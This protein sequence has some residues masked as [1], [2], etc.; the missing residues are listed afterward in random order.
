MTPNIG[1]DSRNEKV[2]TSQCASAYVE[3]T[4]KL[5]NPNSDKC[6]GSNFETNPFHV[7]GT[8]FNFTSLKGLK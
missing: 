6:V 2:K 5:A 4:L 1:Y 8:Y 3:M 7:K